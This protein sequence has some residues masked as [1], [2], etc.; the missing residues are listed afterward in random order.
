MKKTIAIYPGTFDPITNAHVDLL[1]R[2]LLLFDKVI[3]AIAPNPNK[4]PDFTIKERIQMAQDALKHIKN[5]R[6]EVES[7]EG[8]LVDYIRRKNANVIIRG[9]RAVSD[10]EYEFQMALMNRTLA[11]DIETIYMMPGDAYTFLSS[12][13]VKEVS[14]LGG[15]VSRLVPKNVYKALQRK[16]QRVAY[17]K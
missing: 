15:N 9:L 5:N 14:Q 10:F 3:L 8:L 1:E 11:P 12:H 17:K 4:N 7:F 16:Y 13:I 2:G 6:L